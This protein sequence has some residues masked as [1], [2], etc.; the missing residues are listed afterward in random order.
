[1]GISWISFG[2]IPSIK[3][4]NGEIA[5]TVSPLHKPL[6]NAAVTRTRLTREPVTICPKDALRD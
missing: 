1:M 3:A 6:V 4:K 2:P 5:A